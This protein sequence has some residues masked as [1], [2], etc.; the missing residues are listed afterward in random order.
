MLV[1][2]PVETPRAIVQVVRLAHEIWNEHFPQ[3]ISQAQIDYMLD[4]FQSA[5]AITRQI[6][7]GMRYFLL[8]HQGQ[9][10][11]FLA[12]K[13]EPD[14]SRLFVS[15]LYLRAE[16]RGRG[17]ARQAL[18]FTAS[19]GEKMGL[20]TIYLTCNKRNRVPLEIYAHLGFRQVESVVKD[21]GGGFV[22]DDYILEKNIYTP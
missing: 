7:E 17:L 6:Q 11:G 8:S 3:V 12:L 2:D 22:M 9:S 18:D 10:A 1:P 14:T 19:L 13:P 4:R 21:I 16:C 5:P 15:K 20:K